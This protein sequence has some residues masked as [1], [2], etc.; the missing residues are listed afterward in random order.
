MP[1]QLADF[2]TCW[3]AS[4]RSSDAIARIFACFPPFSQIGTASAKHQA[5][6]HHRH[7]NWKNAKVQEEEMVKFDR[8][9]M[10][11]FAV[12]AMGALA[13][14][15]VSIVAAASPAKAAAAQSIVKG[16]HIEFAAK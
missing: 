10:Q 12:S 11:R 2:P 4:N 13:L 9:D 5:S 6:R 16:H 3:Q 7:S 8:T 1:S 14:T 15:A